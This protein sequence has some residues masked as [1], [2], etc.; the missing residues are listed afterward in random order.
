MIH[1]L[2]SLWHRLTHEHVTLAKPGLCEIELCSNR[3]RR[4]INAII[5]FEHEYE[6]IRL[7]GI[8][9]EHGRMLFEAQT[10]LEMRRIA[11][12]LRGGNEQ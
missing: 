7:R 12:R 6:P 4:S 8:T 2:F 1:E 10:P 9:L 5:S 3:F 11:V